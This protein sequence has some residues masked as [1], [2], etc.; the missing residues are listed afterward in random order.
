MFTIFAP[1]H[2]YM[3]YEDRELYISNLSPELE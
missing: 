3:F 1:P 2:L